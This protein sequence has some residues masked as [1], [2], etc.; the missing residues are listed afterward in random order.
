MRITADHALSLH[1]IVESLSSKIHSGRDNIYLADDITGRVTILDLSPEKFGTTSFT[2]GDLRIAIRLVIRDREVILY[3][4]LTSDRN[5]TPDKILEEA[6][7]NGYLTEFKGLRKP[8]AA[9]NRDGHV[10]D[11]GRARKPSD[12]NI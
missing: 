7:K 2:A 6:I 5:T 12:D 3:D 10:P 1:T 4:S 9:G 11:N 8:D